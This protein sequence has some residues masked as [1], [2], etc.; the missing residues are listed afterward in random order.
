[1]I[2]VRRAIER[3]PKHRWLGLVVLV[4]FAFLLALLVFHSVTDS[5][6]LTAEITCFFVALVVVV[7]PVVAPLLR[8][9]L[10][11]RQRSRGPPATPRLVRAQARPQ[12]ALVLP[13]RL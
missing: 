7:V 1:M 2:R 13:L 6:E 10:P 3:S 12:S 9:M 11:R 4:L 8:R 5:A